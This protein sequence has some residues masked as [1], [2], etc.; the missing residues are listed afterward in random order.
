MRMTFGPYAEGGTVVIT[1]DS[2]VLDYDSPLGNLVALSDDGTSLVSGDGN[3]FQV[4]T[5]LRTILFGD[6]HTDWYNYIFTASSS[7]YVLA[8]RTLTVTLA[9]AHNWWPGLTVTMWNRDY[10]TWVNPLELVIVAIPTTTTFTVVM[11]AG[12]EDLPN[13]ALTGSLQMR[14]PAYRGNSNYVNLMQM[15]LGWPLDIV[16]IPAQSGEWSTGALAR[17]SDVTSLNPQLVIMN[18]FGINDQT[19]SGINAASPFNNEATTIANNRAIFDAILSTGAFLIVGTIPPTASGDARGTIDICDRVIRLN[20]DIWRYARG[21]TRML[22]FDMHSAVI[23]PT[24]AVGAALAV[25]VRVDNVHL[26]TRGA[27]KVAKLLEPFVSNIIAATKSTLPTALIQS[28]NTG[29][30]TV[31]S[32]TGASGVVTV[33]MAA[34]HKWR[35]G[36]QIR[37]TGMGD[38]AA[39]GVFSIASVTSTNLTYAAPGVADGVIS[40]TKVISR[41]NNIFRNNLLATTTGGTL[42]AGSGSISGAAAAFIKC[43]VA[44][45]STSYAAAASVAADDSGFGNKQVLAVTACSADGTPRSQFTV[46]G[47]TAF[48]TEMAGNGRYYSFECRYRLKS[49][50]WANTPISDVRGYL[51]ITGSDGKTYA[52]EAY[53]GWD[54][55]EAASIIE[56]QDWHVRTPA[57]YV[58]VGVTVSSSV[59]MLWAR[60]SAAISGAATLTL[61]LARP[62]VFDVTDTVGALL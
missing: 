1:S 62:A 29:A 59:F 46:P 22:V 42:T 55:S 13:G 14:A 49:S 61:E 17:I 15:R 43:E 56:D 37:V 48:A 53:A 3:Q 7:A 57:V 8:T 31:T 27:I 23:D 4:G 44:N 36:E 19:Y 26:T 54:G 9:S 58:P 33:V 45:T 35:A 34:A 30:K 50:A 52:G 32:A 21:K 18:S 16:A 38:A 41:S 10:A 12:Y 47:T 60:H 28:H 6:S 24:S 25:N 39:N 11:P 40:G 2:A 20:D 51:T 5:G